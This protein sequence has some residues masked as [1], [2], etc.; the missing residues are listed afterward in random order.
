MYAIWYDHVRPLFLLARGERLARFAHCRSNIHMG[1]GP[2]E[3]RLSGRIIQL[4]L[5]DLHVS[6]SIPF[7]LL[8]L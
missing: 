3:C 5:S 8:I 6:V 2:F 4:L 7:L 1:S